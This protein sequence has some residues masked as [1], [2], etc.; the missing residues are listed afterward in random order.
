MSIEERGEEKLGAKRVLRDVPQRWVPHHSIG[1]H[2]TKGTVHQQQYGIWG[3]ADIL[4]G[5]GE[6]ISVRVSQEPAAY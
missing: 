5:H 3:T 2:Q 6:L 1:P 4:V